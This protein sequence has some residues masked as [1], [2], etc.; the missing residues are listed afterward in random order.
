MPISASQVAPI[1]F[2]KSERM[3]EFASAW[4]QGEGFEWAFRIYQEPRRLWRRYYTTNR[5][6]LQLLLLK[7]M[8]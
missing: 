2:A 5:K 7:L 1:F 3:W 6:Y 4:Q 8:Q